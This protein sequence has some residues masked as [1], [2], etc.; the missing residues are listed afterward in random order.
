MPVGKMLFNMLRS[1]YLLF[2][3]LL[4]LFNAHAADEAVFF[5]TIGAG[6]S[7]TQSSNVIVS[8]PLEIT[9]SRLEGVS[10]SSVIIDLQ[11]FTV[12]APD[13][14]LV[15]HG[16]GGIQSTP[17]EVRQYFRGTIRNHPNSF[18]FVGLDST[19]SAKAIIH[20]DSTV[21]VADIASPK[22]G[23]VRGLTARPVNSATDF[24]DRTFQCDVDNSFLSNF[25]K[26][27]TEAGLLNE[28]VNLA[29]RAE[30]PQ[31]MTNPET[32]RR[33]NLIIETDY[34]LYQRLG[35]NTQSYVQDLMAYVSSIYQREANTRFQISRIVVYT[36]AS[37]PWTG[38]DTQSMLTELQSYWNAPSR[39]SISRNHVHL[40]S[41]KNAGGGKAFLNTLASPT[42]A[43]G[44]S[45]NIDGSFVSSNPQVVWDAFVVAHE[46]GHA[47]G[48]SHTHNYDNP[49]VGSNVGGAIDC[50]Y[51]EVGTG[52]CH[53]LLG[54]SPR[55]GQLPGVGSISG[56]TAGD[57][58]G[59]IMSYCHSL[60]GSFGEAGTS[61]IAMTFGKS[62]AFGVNAFRVVDVLTASAKSWLPLDPI[63]S[64]LTVSQSG[65][66]SG[67][68]SIS[69]AGITCD[70]ECSTSLFTNTY[71]TLTA[72]AAVGSSFTGWSGS[73]SGASANCTVFMLPDTRVTASFEVGSTVEPLRASGLDGLA[74]SSQFFTVN[75]PSGATNLVVQL[76][77]GT[78]DADLFV[79]AGQAVSQS[80]F[81][82]ASQ[83]LGNEELCSFS[84]PSPSTY[85]ILV[86]GYRSYTGATLTASYRFAGSVQTLTLTKAGT[87]SG[88][89]TSN[90]AGIDCGLDCQETFA[91]GTNITL[92]AAASAGSSFTGWSG[93]CSG[94]GMCVVTM[95]AAKSV[96]ANFSA[97]AAY[98]VSVE[99]TGPGTGTVT[100]APAGINCGT[101]CSAS[102]A[103]GSTVTL[104]ATPSG[105]NVFIR[106]EGACTGTASTCTLTVDAPKSAKA[107]FDSPQSAR[108]N[109]TPILMLLLD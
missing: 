23:G 104:T 85:N 72:A 66:G 5:Q 19:Q 6:Q 42:V 94:T 57:G 43:Y 52:Q 40:I 51:A 96:T 109:I 35:S 41:A 95:D 56:G 25:L 80:N 22:T 2:A 20:A 31:K 83:V 100:S 30:K 82:C 99:K 4:A 28:I 15:V 50:C 69:P 27:N 32:Y 63:S 49:A 54:G 105:N 108:P 62:H 87:G 79:K 9:L 58:N 84:S 93:A 7:L 91:T 75:V 10:E 78:P 26:N 11:P 39:S 60:P 1:T 101:T 55:K 3:L 46:I 103:N 33:A 70:S 97:S 86:Y 98:T 21:V 38:T 13:A 8:A 90:P 59:T 73:C 68:V 102:M 64:T 67:R 92:T 48:S 37:D 14:Q 16:E 65:T 107:R 17:L 74:G 18:A 106:W 53:N 34:E 77:G 29:I 47:F 71:A 89:V 24:A 12:A 88:T 61:N 76:S 36:T 44:V 81:D 45:G